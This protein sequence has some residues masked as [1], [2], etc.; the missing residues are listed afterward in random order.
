MK[1]KHI[2]NLLDEKKL[3]ELSADERERIETHV[4]ECAACRSEYEAA[5]VAHLVLKTRASQTL[6]PTPFFE[7]RVM[8]AWRE[9]Q[10]A[11]KP[12]GDRIRQMWQD[13]KLL[14]SGLTTSVALLAVMSLVVPQAANDAGSMY[15]STNDYYTVESLVFEGQEM[16]EEITDGQLFEAIYGDETEN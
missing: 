9:R 16:P 7:A 4:A 13:A 10:A 3:K 11:L 1:D 15:A 2:V 12:V 5:R 8:N 14:I 6:E